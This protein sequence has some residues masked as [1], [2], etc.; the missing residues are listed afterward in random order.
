MT[1]RLVRALDPIANAP[2]VA[3]VGIAMR[4]RSSSGTVRQQLRWV[5]AG[6]LLAAGGM[7]SI[8]ASGFLLGLPELLINTLVVVGI[9]CVPL[10]ITVRLY[11]LDRIVSRTVTYGALT[12]LLVAVYV[13]LVTV[14]SRLTPS[15]SSLAVASST[16]AVA[17]LFQPLRKRVQAR[18]DRRF[19]RA[20]YDADRTV[21]A[22]RTRL[23]DEVDLD[24]VRGELLGVVRDT[25]QPQSAGVWLRSS[26]ER[27]T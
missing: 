5:G 19:N 22:F 4:F 6:A 26:A 25:L 20:R 2:E 1:G 15:G 27:T 18:V 12:G 23:R 16:L 24:S 13:G 14:V 7:L 3:A 9:G 21:E 17:A 10:S 8:F 11:D